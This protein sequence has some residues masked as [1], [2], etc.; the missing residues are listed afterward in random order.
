MKRAYLFVLFVTLVITV[1]AQLKID[2]EYRPRFEF[3]DGYS[4]LKTEDSEP[5]YFVTQRTRLNLNHTYNNVTSKLSIQDYRVWG[6]SKLKSELKKIPRRF[7]GIIHSCLTLEPGKGYGDY[8]P[9]G[10]LERDLD[11]ESKLNKGI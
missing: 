2:A 3:R 8:Y 6:E 10:Q 11:V 4:T 9:T 7:R 5:A 1:R